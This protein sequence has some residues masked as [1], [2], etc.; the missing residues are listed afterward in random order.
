M[1]TTFNKT[2]SLK[3]KPV[4]NE[5][6]QRKA[7]T[8]H[9]KNNYINQKEAV[10]L[11][12]N[13]TNYLN[14]RQTK[15]KSPFTRVDKSAYTTRDKSM[16][17]KNPNK[18]LSMHNKKI[19][20]V[21]KCEIKQKPNE[22]KKEKINIIEDAKEKYNNHIN[23]RSKRSKSS[24]ILE[25]I[26]E[27]IHQNFNDDQTND[28]A[29]NNFIK[30]IQKKG[31]L[32][33]KSFNLVDEYIV[34]TSE[35]NDFDIFDFKPTAQNETIMD[36]D[37]NSVF[38]KEMNKF[39]ENTFQRQETPPFS[40]KQDKSSCEKN[41]EV[42]DKIRRKSKKEDILYDPILHQYYDKNSNEYFQII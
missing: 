33:I 7:E 27:D 21:E 5:E 11:T 2:S 34:K 36:K 25:C 37:E 1:E 24:M 15:S 16:S 14:K 19:E 28:K 8:L 32:E 3:S 12:S 29:N 13:E 38:D 42:K 23:F 20:T 17:H 41:L 10:N 39:L 40:T 9:Q 18:N 22:E 30:A 6:K 26:E 4:K 35:A 31:T